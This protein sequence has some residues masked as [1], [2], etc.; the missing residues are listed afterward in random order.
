[1][2][3]FCSVKQLRKDA[4]RRISLYMLAHQKETNEDGRET[5]PE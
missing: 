4:I 5:T 2:D 1:M 3:S